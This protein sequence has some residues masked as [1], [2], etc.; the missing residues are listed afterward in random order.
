MF[1]TP[2]TLYVAINLGLLDMSLT[3]S[4]K[5]LSMTGSDSNCL[6]PTLSRSNSVLV[7]LNKLLSGQF[8]TKFDLVRPWLSQLL[9]G[10]VVSNNPLGSYSKKVWGYYVIHQ[11][12]ML[13]EL[14][15]SDIWSIKPRIANKIFIKCLN[16]HHPTE[17]KDYFTTNP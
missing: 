3:R 2:N 8:R 14:V 7:S 17:K 16:R 5:R 12:T 9:L 11:S 10:H 1:L 15:E 6:I 4:S 13:S